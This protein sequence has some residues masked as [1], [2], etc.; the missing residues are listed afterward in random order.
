[1]ADKELR[2]ALLTRLTYWHNLNPYSSLLTS[3]IMIKLGLH[4]AQVKGLI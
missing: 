3:T 1:L 2:I 4:S